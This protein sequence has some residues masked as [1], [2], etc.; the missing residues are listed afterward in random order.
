MSCTE[1]VNKVV[2]IY[3]ESLKES[4]PDKVREAFHPNAKIVGHLHGDF[5]EMST[6]DFAGFVAAQE[7]AEVEYEILST[8]VE[9]STACVKIRDKY[10]GITFLDT[11]SFIK[12]DPCKFLI[13]SIS[14]LAIFSGV[15]ANL[16]SFGV[17]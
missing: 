12:I 4:S 8:V 13:K 3:V 1:S 17:T 2:E 6:E 11:L 14:R 7:P 15:S 5:L 9:G 16:N 10:L